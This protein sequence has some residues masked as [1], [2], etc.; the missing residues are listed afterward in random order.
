[1][2]EEQNLKG[3]DGLWFGIYIS[4]LLITDL[5]GTTISVIPSIPT[6]AGIIVHP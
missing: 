3:S 6:A 5:G 4:I 2:H 1:V